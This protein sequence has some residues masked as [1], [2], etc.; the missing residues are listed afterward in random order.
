MTGIWVRTL[1]GGK[2]KVSRARVTVVIDGVT[3][4]VPWGEQFLAVPPGLHWV[5]VFW[6]AQRPKA[7]STIEVRVPEN[8][9]AVVRFDAPRW[10]W[11]AGRLSVVQ[12]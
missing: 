6:A 4:K 1:M 10:I 7:R 11:Q 3:H 2:L 8:D 5:S 12:S 9:S